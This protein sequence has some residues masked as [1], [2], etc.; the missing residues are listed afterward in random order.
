MALV[1][2]SITF[3]D[4]SIPEKVTF[5]GR[6]T[7]SVHKLLGGDRVVDAMGADESD[8]TWSGRFQ[9][10]NAT[11]LARQLDALRQSGTQ[12]PLIFGSNFY[13]V[14]VSESKCDYERFYQI[15]YSV[16]C[17]VVST[18]GGGGGALGAVVSTL[19]DLVNGDMA[20]V[21]TDLGSF[22]SGVFD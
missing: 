6:Q 14:V 19:D 4:Y 10:A 16:T 17:T 7:L 21:A 8:I 5:G 9:G 3:T 1:L 15:P 20:S 11:G 13:L 2:G 22:A 18:S 12:V